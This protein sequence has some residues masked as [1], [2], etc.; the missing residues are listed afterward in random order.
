MARRA[1]DPGGADWRDKLQPGDVVQVSGT[2]GKQ[3]VK[4]AQVDR[5]SERTTRVKAASGQGDT[6]GGAWFMR[7]ALAQKGTGAQLA[8]QAVKH[9]KEETRKH[10]RK[11]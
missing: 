8:A 9:A 10:G 7:A 2:Q 11:S 1:T 4:V 3:W 6:Y 5:K